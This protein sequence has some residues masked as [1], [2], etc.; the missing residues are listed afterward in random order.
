MPVR[1]SHVRDARDGMLTPPSVGDP[2][3]PSWA[4]YL[5]KVQVI[6]HYPFLSSIPIF[7]QYSEEESHGL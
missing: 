5:G 7:F 2:F 4:G 1:P 6:P 3:R